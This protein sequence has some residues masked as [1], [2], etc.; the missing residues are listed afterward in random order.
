[1]DRIKFKRRNFYNPTKGYDEKF[2]AAAY[3]YLYI[4]GVKTQWSVCYDKYNLYYED[5]KEFAVC[6]RDNKGIV[7][8]HARAAT[9][10]DLA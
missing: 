5:D 1:M 10:G 3:W 6:Q 9:L 2:V 8:T 7:Y 4:N